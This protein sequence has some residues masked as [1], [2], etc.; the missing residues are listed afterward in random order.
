MN[1][2]SDRSQLTCVNSCSC[3]AGVPLAPQARSRGRARAGLFPLAMATLA[4]ATA[5]LPAGPGRAEDRSDDAAWRRQMADLQIMVFFQ[6]KGSSLPYDIGATGE[7]YRRVPAL[8]NQRVVLGANSSGSIPAAYFSAFGFTDESV[9]YAEYRLQRADRKA[10]RDM[11][12]PSSMISKFLLGQ[13]T[14]VDHFALRE[15]IAFALG[16]EDWQSARSLADVV[17]ASRARPV[18]PVLIAAANKEVLD[19][20]GPGGPTD[21]LDYKEMDYRDFSVSWKP[22]VY[23]FYRQRPERFAREHPNLIL[24]SDRRIGKAATFFVDRSMYELLRQ[25][26]AA[27]RLADLR[28]MDSPADLALAIE[29][30]ASEPT[31]FDPIEEPEPA[32]LMTGDLPGD[33]GCSRR[34]IYCGGFIMPLGAQD[35]R[36][37]LPGIRVLGSGFVHNPLSV[38]NFLQTEYL[39]D[40]E[41][42]AHLNCW[43]ADMEMNPDPDFQAHVVAHN[44]PADQ[45]MAAG[46]ARARQCLDADHALPKFVARPEF[47]KAA[48]RAILPHSADVGAGSPLKTLR[49]LGPLLAPA[50]PAARVA[51]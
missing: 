24:G 28:L 11:E 6:G 33:L 27:E 22:E 7:L 5:L 44:L 20:Q 3:G 36:R 43:W 21:A 47:D 42:I 45:E 26:P 49:G 13:R 14:E 35:T 51:Q 38:R 2:L 15:Y 25:V 8:R 4:V 37:M 16:V 39:A 23:E 46:R 29:A 9:R 50:D 18:Y 19:N 32:K 40:V 1:V 31:Y 17:R 10:V 30:S 41:K 34:R 48:R 12:Q